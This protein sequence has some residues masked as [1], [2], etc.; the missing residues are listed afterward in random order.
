MSKTISCRLKD[1]EWEAFHQLCQRNKIRYHDL[2]RAIV[3]DALIEEGFDALR[4]DEPKGR[5]DG[6]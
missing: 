5:E 4:P 2:L 3:L 6:G 1:N